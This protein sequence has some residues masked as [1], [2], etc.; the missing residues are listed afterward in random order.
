MADT[1]EFFT[2]HLPRRL[3]NHPELGDSGGVF[4]F[5]IIGAGVWTVDL[6]SG[7][8]T[9]GP[10]DHPG[11]R[12]TCHR[13]DWEGILD[14]PG[15]ATQAFMMGKLKATNIAMATRLAKILG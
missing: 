15:K 3:A 10:H 9:E 7:S 8:V 6:D 13:T 11:C 4:Q 1:A 12:I 2:D 5:D 14:S